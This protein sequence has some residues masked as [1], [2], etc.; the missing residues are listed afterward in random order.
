MY[1]LLG[2]IILCGV[3]YAGQISWSVAEMN[4]DGEAWF[5][6]ASYSVLNSLPLIGY[7]SDTYGV[8]VNTLF[9]GIENVPWPAKV[10]AFIQNIASA[11]LLF[12]ALLAIR[13]YFKLG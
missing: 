12:F 6:L 10:V 11:I 2:L 8:A 1:W 9:G 4:A 7:A 13:N 3:F 5:D